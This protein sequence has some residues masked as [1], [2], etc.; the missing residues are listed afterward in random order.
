MVFSY[1]KIN[2]EY[3]LIKVDI[4]KGNMV[5]KFLGNGIRAEEMVAMLY[6]DLGFAQPAVKIINPESNDPAVGGVAVM[7]F[8]DT[9]FFGL[10]N[11]KKDSD[12]RVRGIEDV[13]P[14]H[15]AEILRFL[16]GNAIIGNS[17]RHGGNFMWGID[18][19]TGK[20]R[21]IPIDNGLA[22]FNGMFGN[23]EKNNSNPLFLDP[24][25]IL[26]S[27]DY[28]NRNA[29]LQYGAGYVDNVGIDQAESEIVEFA[30]RM[31]E[32]AAALALIDDRAAGYIDA[33]AEYVIKNARKLAEKIRRGY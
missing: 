26:T 11:I 19:D 33:R 7:E 29:A 28:G 18:P 1:N 10:Q 25:R 15:R 3:V 6:K 8:A 32:R 9:G 12:A 24:I 13:M 2:G 14:E 4:D 31:R 20:A 16:V 5:G 30:N 21:I 23:A 17:D 27:R 22:L